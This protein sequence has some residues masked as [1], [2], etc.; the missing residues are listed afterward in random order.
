M[1][2]GL[3]H[4]RRWLQVKGAADYSNFDSYPKDLDIPPDETSGWDRDF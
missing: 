3:F 2:I 1:I 4:E